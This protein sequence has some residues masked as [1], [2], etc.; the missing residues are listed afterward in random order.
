MAKK[1]GKKQ[2]AAA[3]EVQA[4]DKVD[5]KNQGQ[6]LDSLKDELGIRSRI[7]TEQKGQL[8]VSRQL[9]NAASDILASQDSQA[10][11]LRKQKDIAKDLEKTNKIIQ[12][13]K[14]EANADGEKANKIA[15]DQLDIAE[16]LKKA[17][18]EEDK[19]R[20]EIEKKVGLTGKL[21]KGVSDIPLIGKM[22]DTEEALN[23]MNVAA[24]EGKNQFQVMGVG[25]ATLGKQIQQHMTDPLF[26][27]SNLIKFGFKFDK[28]VTDLGKSLG[29]SREEAKGMRN[30]F[31]EL[32]TDLN[33]VAITS[34]E[35]QAGFNMVNNALGTASTTIRA[36]IVVEAGRMQK[37]L[38]LSEE[39]IMGFAGHAMRSGKPM[40]KIKHEA[41]GALKAVESES[42]IRLNQTKM[43]EKAGKV[44][45]QISAQLGGDPAKIMASVAA[46]A[47]L[48][49]ELE[50]VAAAGKTMLNFEESIS[51][52]LEAELL[53]G[54]Q[55][56]LE[57]ARLAA[58]TGDY[59]TL[60]EEINENVGDFGDFSQMNVLQQEALAKSVGMTADQLSNQLMKKADLATLAQEARDAGDEETA[61]MLEQRN[62]QEE[63]NDLIMQ[64]K[65][66][67]VDMAGGP[68][69]DF[70]K[71][72]AAIATGFGK[73]LG[74]AKQLGKYIGSFAGGLGPFLDKL[75]FVGKMLKGLAWVV[76][77][78]AAFM[79]Y[80]SLAAIP[81]IG[82]PLGLAAALA[83]MSMGNAALS[84][85][86]ADDAVIPGAPGYGKRALLEKGAVTLFNDRDTIVA[87]TNINTR[88]AAISPPTAVSEQ[89]ATD[90]ASGG[91]GGEP[92]PIVVTN[93]YSNDVFA[94]TDKNS[95][96]VYMA[97][98]KSSGLFA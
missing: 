14:R 1:K 49:M 21:I 64:L 38:G 76:V 30:H 94:R 10:L 17:L 80:K 73:V 79:A 68:V 3:E 95:E 87:G 53:T 72:V 90:A 18:E 67:F 92:T 51:A 35:M 4:F 29:M 84:K 28:E 62:A 98:T 39:A 82:V 97:Q 46:A 85:K 9:Q 40:E 45:G 43:L 59:E 22:V 24:E 27:I 15:K 78:L 63:F 52:E 33:E 12:K 20:A 31:S 41:L 34:T 26:V 42:G 23:N 71:G 47:E 5:L 86:K 19:K 55:L 2:K 36:D 16:K 50:A 65:Q 13:L 66:S 83:V 48:G 81:I 6:M 11:G 44:Q 60:T 70:L 88:N 57:K 7:T 77:T 32:A 75:G 89:A 61:K 69:G 25:I 91:G 54:K 37:L 56:N 74:Y 8:D 96:D 58:L 93:T